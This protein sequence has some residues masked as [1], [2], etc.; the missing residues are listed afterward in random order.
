[1]EVAR[2]KREDLMF[3]RRIIFGES[4]GCSVIKSKMDALY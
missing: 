2:R 4:C 1:M 3:G